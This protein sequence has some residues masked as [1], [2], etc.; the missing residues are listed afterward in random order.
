MTTLNPLARHE[1]RFRGTNLLWLEDPN[2]AEESE[3]TL[4]VEGNEVRVHWVFR[5]TPHTGVLRYDFS[6]DGDG[7]VLDWTDTWH[8]EEGMRLTG[9]Q[10]DGEID[11]HGT[12]PAGDGPPWGWRVVLEAK[13]SERLLLRMFNVPPGGQQVRAVELDGR[14]E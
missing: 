7:V 9:R 2:T 12:Y 5:G 8:A 3:G 6:S 11:V 10:Q 4:E 14:R 1:G 13:D